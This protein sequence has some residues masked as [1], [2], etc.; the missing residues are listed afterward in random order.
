MITAIKNSV[1][2][3]LGGLWN[4]LKCSLRTH[5]WAVNETGYPFCS[6]CGKRILEWSLDARNGDEEDNFLQKKYYISWLIRILTNIE[7]VLYFFGF[8]VLFPFFLL[9]YVVAE[10]LLLIN[11]TINVDILW[12]PL[13]VAMLAMVYG[14]YGG[15]IY[16]IAKGVGQIGAGFVRD[17][18]RIKMVLCAIVSDSVA[19]A[20]SI[21]VLFGVATVSYLSF[22]EISN[23]P[24]IISIINGE[25]RKPIS[26]H[27]LSMYGAAL[28][29]TSMSILFI[30]WELN[31]GLAARRA[32]LF[33]VESKVECNRSMPLMTR[34]AHLS[35]LHIVGERY[36]VRMEAGCKAP[37]GNQVFEQILEKLSEL[38]QGGKVDHVFLTGDVTD[39]GRTSE[40]GEF[41]DM[42]RKHEC[43]R[44]CL[45]FVPGNHDLNIPDRNNPSRS[46]SFFS[47]TRAM[48]QVRLLK[49]MYEI[50]GDRV[51]LLAED[52][53]IDISLKQYLD[54]SEVKLTLDAYSSGLA[55]AGRM[56][57]NDI[58]SNVFPLCALPSDSRGYGVIL[59]DSNSAASV[60]FTNALGRLSKEQIGKLSG[61]IR[62]NNDRTWIVLLHHHLVEV[63]RGRADIIER[64]GTLLED[65]DDL[66][67]VLRAGTTSTTI[68]MHG[69]RHIEW[70]GSLDKKV[71]IASA[72]SSTLKHS[73][74]QEIELD[75][76][77]FELRGTGGNGL[78]S[79]FEHN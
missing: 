3:Y 63:G 5:R 79:K 35:D 67:N 70:F 19:R 52:G 22:I 44:D 25:F 54:L 34:I 58:W 78:L 33:V 23:D 57:I 31:S 50:Q 62:K 68:V 74:N 55:E 42:L 26:M 46:D 48:R 17:W 6:C 49:A 45:L 1:A 77:C 4:V 36:G 51:N 2:D 12:F 32:S 15:Y 20:I 8:R 64:A 27:L 30:F 65:A 76:Q 14:F 56:S 73:D 28:V 21:A 71:F 47:R 53:T 37:R 7:G 60:S 13:W 40:W 38:K 11:T 72:R 43:I 41:L 9:A 10:L 18:F 61:L 39:S 59:L 75:F 16:D 24:D 66:L 29:S 69:H